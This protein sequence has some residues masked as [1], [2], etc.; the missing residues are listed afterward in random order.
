MDTHKDSKSSGNICR[1]CGAAVLYCPILIS[2]L[3]TFFCMPG[4]QVSPW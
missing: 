4:D 2:I 1:R 3:N